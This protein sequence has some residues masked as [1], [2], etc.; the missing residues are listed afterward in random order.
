MLSRPPHAVFCVCFISE[1]HAGHEGL[2]FSLGKEERE[3]INLVQTLA[4][5]CGHNSAPHLQGHKFCDS[6]V[7]IQPIR[8]KNLRLHRED[9][10]GY[11]SS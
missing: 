11:G 2:L 9:G 3:R 1:M 7:S 6:S 5:V 8:S 10:D 4:V